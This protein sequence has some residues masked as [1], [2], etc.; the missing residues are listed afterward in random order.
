VSRCTCTVVPGNVPALGPRRE[1]ENKC[2]GR[3]IR[4]LPSE[5]S[6][7]LK[8]LIATAAVDQAA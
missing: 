1:K 8:W 6:Q 4:R 5:W 7:S 2:C 3:L